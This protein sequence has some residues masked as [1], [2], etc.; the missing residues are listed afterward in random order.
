M[1]HTVGGMA[2]N[3]E[4]TYME[5]TKESKERICGKSI[6]N[7]LPEDAVITI[8]YYTAS[9]GDRMTAAQLMFDDDKLD[10]HIYRGSA[11]CSPLDMFCKKTG[12]KIAIVRACRDYWAYM[13]AVA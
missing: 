12:R 2:T 9:N 3:P 10:H 5:L 13:K 7:N 8:T 6:C 11:R 1:F 4:V